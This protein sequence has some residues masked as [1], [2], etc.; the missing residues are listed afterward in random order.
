MFLFW[1]M[2]IWCALVRPC[3]HRYEAGNGPPRSS[4]ARIPVVATAPRDFGLRMDRAST[5]MRQML[6]SASVAARRASP[7]TARHHT[8][9]HCD[10]AS[11]GPEIRRP[12]CP[13][14]W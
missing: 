13:A 3:A 6:E 2:L 5:W 12:Q 1:L 9:G 8:A 7:D 11:T 10:I 4:L 14:V